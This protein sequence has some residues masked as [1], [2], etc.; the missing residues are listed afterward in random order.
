M[1]VIEISMG[2]A[3]LLY[4]LKFYILLL[5]STQFDLYNYS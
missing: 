2:V 1:Y 3:L 4:K 5:V